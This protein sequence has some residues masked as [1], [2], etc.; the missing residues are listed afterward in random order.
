MMQVVEYQILEILQ[1]IRTICFHVE[2]YV[3]NDDVGDGTEGGAELKALRSK[4]NEL[5]DSI[6]TR[7]PGDEV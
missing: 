7:R 4:I 6:G 5:I 1:A 3:R 2:R